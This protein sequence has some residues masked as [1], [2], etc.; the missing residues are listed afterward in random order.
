MTEPRFVWRRDLAI[1]VVD[2]GPDERL[3]PTALIDLFQEEAGH[4]ARA[5]G[6][7]T[8]A[9]QGGEEPGLGTWVLSRLAL[10]VDRWPAALEPLELATWPSHYDGLRAH[11]DFALRDADGATVAR[12]TSVWF[13]LDLARRRPTRLPPEV[14]RFGPARGQP[15]ALE[16]GD[17]PEP[18][19]AAESALGFTVRWAD[20]DRVGHANNAR[21]AEWALETVPASTRETHAL[22][23]LDLSFQREAVAGDAV[24]SERGP[25]EA[26]AEAVAFRHRIARDGAPLALVRSV[27][28][29]RS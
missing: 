6:L 4:Q 27:W 7:E 22:A 14:L 3:K 21:Y 18:P 29:A 9:L 8:F 12:A 2:V 5:Y 20:L 16:T 28:R 17:A 26:R 19:E 1:R 25:A 24:V 11:R 15:R 13:V 10:A 23:G